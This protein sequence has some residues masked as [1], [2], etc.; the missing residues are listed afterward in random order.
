[1]VRRVGGVRNGYP[2]WREN[3]R[4][5]DGHVG[6]DR[7]RWFEAVA[8]PGPCVGGANFFLINFFFSH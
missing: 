8:D 2:W 1:M 4:I 3:A 7:G 5:C 6:V